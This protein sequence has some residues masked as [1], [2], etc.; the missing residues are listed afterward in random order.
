MGTSISKTVN[1]SVEFDNKEG[2]HTNK[3]EGNWPQIKARLPTHGRKK[4]NFS[5]YL[6]ELKWRYIHG[7]EDLWKAFLRDIKKIYKFE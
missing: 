7:G 3:I 6:A 4:E 5:S 2:F 1:H